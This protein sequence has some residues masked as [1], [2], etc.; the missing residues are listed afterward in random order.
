MQAII[1]LLAPAALVVAALGAATAYSSQHP[2]RVFTAEVNPI[3]HPSTGQPVSQ[4]VR[5]NE[6]TTSE[7]AMAGTSWKQWPTLTDF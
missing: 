7:A 5:M 2:K 6:P 4:P 1:K 3:P